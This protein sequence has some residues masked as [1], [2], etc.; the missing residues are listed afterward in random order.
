[1]VLCTVYR[2]GQLTKCMSNCC[3]CFPLQWSAS[4]LK[5]TGPKRTGLPI[6][7]PPKACIK[8]PGR[9]NTWHPITYGYIDDLMKS[10]GILLYQFGNANISP[11]ML[12]RVLFYLWIA[13]PHLY[14]AYSLMFRTDGKSMCLSG[15]TLFNKGKTHGQLH[16]VNQGPAGG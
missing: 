7:C 9:Y 14:N 5:R 16:Y 6:Q 13:L 1:M 4:A 2:H 10:Q 3:Y 15:Y 12:S 11:T 8:S